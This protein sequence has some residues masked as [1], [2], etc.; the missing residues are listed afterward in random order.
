MLFPGLQCVESFTSKLPNDNR[1]RGTCSSNAF[2]F[3][4]FSTWP[5]QVIVQKLHI[6]T[7]K[8]HLA[9]L[10]VHHECNVI[11]QCVLPG[12]Y[13]VIYYA[14]MSTFNSLQIYCIFCLRTKSVVSQRQ[15]SSSNPPDNTHLSRIFITKVVLR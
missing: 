1:A 4:F 13:A 12:R 11:I 14:K 10:L 15:V 9:S 2:C 7:L 6:Y 8:R 5:P 3:I